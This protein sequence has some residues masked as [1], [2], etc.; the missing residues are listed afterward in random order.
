MR[1]PVKRFA[2]TAL[3]LGNFVTGISVI[4]P[5]AMLVDLSAGLGVTIR[6]AGL[7]I[8]FGAIALTIASPL[9]AWLTS[10]I[11]RRLLLSGT[12]LAIAVAHIASAFAPD[13][14]SLL[15]IRLLMLAI[16]ALFTP[17]AAGTAALLVPA[18]K[19]G[20][21]MSYVF[22]GWSLAAALGL[23]AVTYVASHFGW[24]VAYGGIGAAALVAFALAAWR[25]PS[26][27]SG[28]PV[29]VRTWRDLARNPL[30]LLLLAITALQMGGQFVVF[31]FLGPL[32]TR[33]TNASTE[34][35]AAVFLVW[36][37]AGFIGNVIATRLVDSWGAWKTS[38]LFGSFLLVGVIGWAFAMGS[39]WSALFAIV[40]WGLAFAAVNSMQQIRL[41]AAAPPL[42]GASVS[43]NTSVLYIGQGVGS[44]IGGVLYARDM[45]G[46][47][48][49]AA[50]AFVALALVLTMLT[51]PRIAST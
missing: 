5:A 40:F 37:T 47:L 23:P 42:A 49:S 18:S 25:L 30:V 31:T 13:Y 17:Q 1:P 38:L 6:D 46:A 36:G 10:G 32:L 35:V 34:A 14:N 44:A 3:M 33:S 28:A 45:F 19:R 15:V 4:A 22:L 21:T 7:L 8:T 11:D 26:G 12:L 9:T 16:A 48:D 41:V 29:D 2:P 24:R 20:S 43:L 51:R 27:L 50:I 39:Y